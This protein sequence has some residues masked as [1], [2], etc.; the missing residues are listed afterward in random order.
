MIH[1]QLIPFPEIPTD[2]ARLILEMAAWEDDKTAYTLVFVSKVVRQCKQLAAFRDSIISRSDT[3]F[4]SCAVKRLCIGDLS[5]GTLE[6]RHHSAANIWTWMRAALEACTGV[7]RLAIWLTTREMEMHWLACNNDHLRPTHMSFDAMFAHCPNLAHIS[8]SGT[9]VQHSSYDCTPFSLI[10]SPLLSL[11][12][13][14]VVVF[15]IV[16]SPHPHSLNRILEEQIDAI[17]EASDRFVVVCHGTISLQ[18]KHTLASE[19][20]SWRGED[21]WDLAENSLAS[22]SESTS[23]CSASSHPSTS[24]IASSIT[25]S[26]PR[27]P[28]ASS[29]TSKIASS[30]RQTFRKRK[31]TSRVTFALPELKTSSLSPARPS[32]HFAGNPTTSLHISC[33]SVKQLQRFLASL[34]YESYPN[35]TSLEIRLPPL[36]EETIQYTH[37]RLPRSGKDLPPITKVSLWGWNL[38]LVNWLSANFRLTQFRLEGE[39]PCDRTCMQKLIDANMETSRTLD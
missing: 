21:T 26:P 3:A 7:E 15:A 20:G 33:Q 38:D 5:I 1:L 6:F 2:I 35:V 18:E 23:S 8:L 9:A 19:W 14:T 39:S 30:L 31:T 10:V 27:S 16:L 29:F 28:S 12:P 24:E 22:L 36:Q 4:F 13:A 25:S 32:G 37:L 17:S 11:L 34:S